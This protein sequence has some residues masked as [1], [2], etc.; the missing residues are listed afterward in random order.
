[1]KKLLQ[2]TFPLIGMICLTITLI[3]APALADSSDM[4]VGKPLD[5]QVILAV[6]D[7]E[8]DTT[9]EVFSDPHLMVTYVRFHDHAGNRVWTDI[10]GGMELAPVLRDFYGDRDALLLS[11]DSEPEVSLVAVIG[12][13]FVY[14]IT[15]NGELVAIM[16]VN[17]ESGTVNYHIIEN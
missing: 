9:V 6:Q 14:H 12:N 7:P 8:S 10:K 5:M 13:I 2:R 15:V 3:S 16:I 11:R 4:Q 1:M 17:N